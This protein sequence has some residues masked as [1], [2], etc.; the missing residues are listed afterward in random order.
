M[1]TSFYTVE[2]KSDMKPYETRCLAFEMY[3]EGLG[4]DP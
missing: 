3:L 2:Q 4:S 1:Q